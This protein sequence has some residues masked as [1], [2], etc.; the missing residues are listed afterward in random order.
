MRF[1]RLKHVVEVDRNGSITAAANALNTTQSTVTKSVAAMEQE[2]GFSLFVRK[3]R[4]VVATE[5]GQEFLTRASRVLSDFEQLVT[6]VRAQQ[7]EANTLL[8]IGVS[9]ALMQGLLNRAIVEVISSFPDV[10]LQVQAVPAERGVRLL[11]RGDVDVLVGPLHRLTREPEFKCEAIKP[12]EAGLYTR[13][14]HPLADKTNIT[15]DD[16]KAYPMVAPDPQNPYTEELLQLLKED[17]V[18]DPLRQL[19]I[20]EY[21]PMVAQIVQATDAVSSVSLDYART[22]A[23][24]A[25]F[26]L[27][28]INIFTTLEMGCA[29]RTRWL[30]GR[31]ARMFV[32]A[33]KA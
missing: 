25:K 12:M 16:L 27:L 3:A 2:L 19:H 33:L 26:K 15:R 17:H 7:E 21:F 5:K 23:F 29:W 8:R 10:R 1:T 30:P 20:V 6:D 31:A 13:K 22:K 11:Q 18:H 24:R 32:H 9:P 4:G 14:G 28:D